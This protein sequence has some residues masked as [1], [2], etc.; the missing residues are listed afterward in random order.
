MVSKIQSNII[1]HLAEITG[2]DKS[3]I[4]L[5]SSLTDELGL[6]SMMLIDFHRSV[7]KDFPELRNLSLERLLTLNELTVQNIIDIILEELGLNN[8]EKNIVI[9]IV[10]LK[11]LN[12]RI[13]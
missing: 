11:L 4:M 9:L 6:D 13:I 5:S 8:I 7:T 3:E 10:F 12:L 2:Y 1:N